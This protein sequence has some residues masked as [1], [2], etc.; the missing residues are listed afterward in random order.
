MIR[1]NDLVR[2]SGSMRAFGNKKYLGPQHMRHLKDKHEIYF[3]M[4]EVAYVHVALERGHVS[5]S[6]FKLVQC[7]DLPG[8]PNAQKGQ[9][10]GRPAPT[11][12]GASAY[13][14]QSTAKVDAG[15][16]SHLP[17]LERRIVEHLLQNPGNEDGVHVG[18]IARAVGGTAV[19]IR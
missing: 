2:V 15:Q 13:T 17:E 16:W 11:A 19:E 1:E 4:L 18:G 7:T 6:H 3:H 14:A 12:A 10:N 9:T 8:Q 5:G